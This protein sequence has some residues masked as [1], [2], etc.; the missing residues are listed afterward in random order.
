VLGG[1]LDAAL[2]A[3]RWRPT[4]GQTRKMAADVAAAMAYLHGPPPG[5][6]APVPLP[7]AR[8]PSRRLRAHGG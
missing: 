3:Q 2:Y 5:F 6:G 7:R 8:A 1:A 4:I